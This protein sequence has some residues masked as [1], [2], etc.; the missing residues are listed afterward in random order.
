MV[1]S[2]KKTQGKTNLTLVLAVIFLDMIPKEQAT[3]TKIN[4][5]DYIKLKSVCTAQ[6]ITNQTKKQPKEW[7]KIL[8]NHKYNKALTFKTYKEFLQLNSKKTNNPIKKWA[9]DLNTHFPKKT[10]K[11]PTGT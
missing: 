5:W 7:E 3:K 1:K 6:E 2:Q 4:Q 8:A 9:K 11:W 10:C